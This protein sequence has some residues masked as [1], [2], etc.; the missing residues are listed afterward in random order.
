MFSIISSLIICYPIFVSHALY[1]CTGDVYWLW[2]I[3]INVGRL[4]GFFRAKALFSWETPDKSD[5]VLLNK[6]PKNNFDLTVLRRL[7][8]FA[9]HL[10]ITTF[11][12]QFLQ[13]ITIYKKSQFFSPNFIST[14][15]SP[16]SCRSYS[17]RNKICSIN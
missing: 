7:S 1:F 17:G 5:N 3:Y 14:V 2:P 6:E 15:I 11:W 9:T 12:P 10:S 4:V 13:V 8:S 16:A